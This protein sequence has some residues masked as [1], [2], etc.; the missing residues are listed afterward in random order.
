MSES[1]TVYYVY[2]IVRDGFDAGRAPAGLDDAVVRSGGGGRAGGLRA[3][4]SRLPATLYGAASLERN[5]GDVEWVGPRA[6]AH[7]RVLSWAH[8]HGGVLPMPMFSLWTSE[9]SLDRWLA[10]REPDLARLFDRVAGA[11]EF[12]L[13]VHRR[14]DVMAGALDAVDDDI[15]RLRA[16]AR[17]ASPGQRY[18]LERKIAEQ[19]KAAMR[20]AS[21]RMAAA[22]FDEL[23]TL[24]RDAV[25]RPLSPGPAAGPASQVEGTLVLN[26]AFL[27]ARERNEQ[28]RSAVASL[29]RTHEPLGLVFDFT[30]PWPPYNFVAADARAT[31]S[32]R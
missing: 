23:R 12:G 11:D 29:L 27:V 3:L 15:A 20:S 30:G 5:A 4:V 13:R 6:A 7:D 31:A 2:G 8:D 18:L 25:A 28:F 9:E 32:T 10:Q 21:Q 19:A 14:D 17:S 24:A 1:S 22:I 16:E 26:G